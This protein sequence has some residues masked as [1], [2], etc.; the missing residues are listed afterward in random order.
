[1]ITS[2]VMKIGILPKDQTKFI[3]VDRMVI[4]LAHHRVETIV[5]DDASQNK[6]IFVRFCIIYL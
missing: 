4:S 6:S 1:M 2:S 5:S 3:Q